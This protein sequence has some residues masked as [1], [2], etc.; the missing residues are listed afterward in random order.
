MHTRTLGTSG[1][2]VSAIGLGCMS[3]TGGYSGRP[4]RQEMISLLHAAVDRGVTFFDTAE[5]YGPHANEELVG[6]ALAPVRDQVVIATKFAADIDPATRTPSG[7]MLRPDE[8]PRV[9][10]GSLQRLGDEVIDLYYQHRVNP[11]VPIEEFAGAVKDLI[12]AGKVKRFGMSEAAAGTIRRAH[13]VQPVTAVQSEYSLWWRRPEEGVLDVCEELGIGLLPYAPLGRAMLTGRIQG[14]SDLGAD[15]ARHRWPRFAEE[16]IDHNVG[17]VGRLEAFAADKGVTAGQLALAW[18]LAQREWIVPI[19]G[20]KRV[21]YLEEN[22]AAAEV[23]LT[24]AEL[25]LI[26]EAV[27]R[28]SVAGERYPPE[29][30]PTWTSAPRG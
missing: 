1:L 12:E 21:A 17:L 25:A 4:D 11:D 27:P 9:V 23:D 7:R 8:L 22:A 29:R 18:L 20:T 16:N 26:D 14:L 28:G 5:I 13:A 30:M 24:S 10:E 3:M 19:P 15:D 6:E 2:T